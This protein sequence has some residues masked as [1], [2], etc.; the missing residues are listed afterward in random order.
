MSRTTKSSL[1]PFLAV[2]KSEV[3]G[4]FQAEGKD[5]NS[6]LE[7]D[8]PDDVGVPYCLLRP[9]EE[10][11]SDLAGDKDTAPVQSFP[12][13]EIWS[14]DEVEAMQIGNAL[15]KRMTDEANIPTPSGW[16]VYFVRLNFNIQISDRDSRG[17]DKFG[18]S[19]QFELH[20]ESTS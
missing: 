12:T 20:L 15:T 18:R 2:L 19:L 13:A 3:D 8:V 14:D 7:Q 16:Q 9:G 11:E 6:W 5:V 10:S 17:P 4:A 1:V